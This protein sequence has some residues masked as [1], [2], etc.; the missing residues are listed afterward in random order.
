VQLRHAAKLR[1]KLYVA[2]C[3]VKPKGRPATGTT[4]RATRAAGTPSRIDLIVRRFAGRE[5]AGDA[6]VPVAMDCK[7]ELCSAQESGGANVWARPAFCV[8]SGGHAATIIPKSSLA[9]CGHKATLRRVFA[10]P[11][12]HLI[13]DPEAQPA[14]STQKYHIDAMF[15]G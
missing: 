9:G 7:R 12:L 6:A 13:I 4:G 2:A 5:F 15:C 10:S 3:G 14:A 8:P 11:M 1:K